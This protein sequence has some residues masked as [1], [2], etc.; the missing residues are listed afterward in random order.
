M[1]KTADIRGEHQTDF[2]STKKQ[3]EQGTAS[4]NILSS[5]RVSVAYKC[6]ISF[7]R[8]WQ[9]PQGHKATSCSSWREDRVGRSRQQSQSTVTATRM[10][11][12]TVVQRSRTELRTQSNTKKQH[13]NSTT[14]P[15]AFTR[16]VLRTILSDKRCQVKS[17]TGI[18]GVQYLLNLPCRLQV[19]CSELTAL[20]LCNINCT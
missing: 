10:G 16:V 15:K 6:S 17:S 19:F 14:R 18:M 20:K 13:Q 3:P 8:P 2:I 12:A 11:L 1:Y 4:R 5:Q 7:W 9:W